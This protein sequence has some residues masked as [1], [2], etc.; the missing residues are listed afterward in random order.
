MPRR[1]VDRYDLRYRC[2][3]CKDT[4]YLH[5]DPPGNLE[6]CACTMG[7]RKR[8]EKAVVL[9]DPDVMRE[10]MQS[11]QSSWHP[12][13]SMSRQPGWTDIHSS[14]LENLRSRSIPIKPKAGDRATIGGDDFIF[15]GEIWILQQKVKPC[16]K[17]NLYSRKLRVRRR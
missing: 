14:D 16:P 2:D 8:L 4:G 13:E 7:T 11:A 3:D 1:V 15:D 12:A 6:Y 9:E 10:S 5:R 17:R